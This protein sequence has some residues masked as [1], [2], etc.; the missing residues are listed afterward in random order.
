MWHVRQ[1]G[2]SVS[3]KSVSHPVH[4]AVVRLLCCFADGV[5]GGSGPNQA[6]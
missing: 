4:I 6:A 5:G 3:L 1:L 2:R